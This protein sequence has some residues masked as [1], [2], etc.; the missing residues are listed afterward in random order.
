MFCWVLLISTLVKEMTRF[1]IADP[2]QYR[3]PVSWLFLIVSSADYRYCFIFFC[4]HLPTQLFIGY[5]VHYRCVW[6]YFSSTYNSFFFIQIVKNMLS[7]CFHGML[8]SSYQ[9]LQIFQ[10][11]KISHDVQQCRAL[12]LRSYCQIPSTEHVNAPIRQP[13]EN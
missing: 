10:L 3:H 5:L 9:L 6:N 4:N 8:K 11:A 12:D 7:H 1:E 13:N 2:Y